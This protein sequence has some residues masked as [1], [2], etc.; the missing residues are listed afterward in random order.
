TNGD[1]R[2][3]HCD[4]P[5]CRSS[6]STTVDSGGIVGEFSSIAILRTGLPAISYYDRTG[7]NLKIA[8]CL[9][10]SCSSSSLDIVDSGGNV[11]QYTTLIAGGPFAPALI[12]Y[13]DVTNGD[14]KSA[15]CG[16]TGC[17]APTFL[18]V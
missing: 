7:G 6:T 15:E 5:A 11:G 3:L 10:R 18:V 12:F 8:Y 9:T 17:A 13:H 14:L 4:D 1:L 2:V 16:L